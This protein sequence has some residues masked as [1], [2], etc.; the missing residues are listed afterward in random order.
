MPTPGVHTCGHW[1]NGS[2][3]FENFFI[4]S[5]SMEKKPYG[6]LKFLTRPIA[7]F[8]AQLDLFPLF[9]FLASQFSI[10]DVS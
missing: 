10:F 7:S 1:I 9:F 6:I 5:F 4:P 2:S 8:H 3:I